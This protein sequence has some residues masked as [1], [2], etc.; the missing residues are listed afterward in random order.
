MRNDDNDDELFLRI[1]W[2]TKVVKTY[3][4]RKISTRCNQDLNIRRTVISCRSDNHYTTAPLHT[5]A[6]L[7]AHFLHNI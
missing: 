3:F 6:S 7:V 1:G 4:H 5:N 2:L